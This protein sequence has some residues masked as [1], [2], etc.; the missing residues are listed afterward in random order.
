MSRN[1][2]P[3]NNTLM[4]LNVSPQSLPYLT[5]PYLTLPHLTLPYLTLPYYLLTSLNCS[6]LLPSLNH[7]PHIGGPVDELFRPP[8]HPRA[9]SPGLIVSSLLTPLAALER[10]ALLP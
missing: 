5:L 8:T 4:P 6:Q 7:A 3:N 2:Y 9:L 1:Y 10:G